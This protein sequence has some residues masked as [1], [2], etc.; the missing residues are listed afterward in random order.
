[1]DSARVAFTEAAGLHLGNDSRGG[2]IRFY[3]SKGVKINGDKGDGVKIRV[4][5]HT[6]S[7]G[8]WEHSPPGIFEFIYIFVF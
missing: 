7:K 8:V 6:V 3:D 2:K 4:C 5:K 1:M